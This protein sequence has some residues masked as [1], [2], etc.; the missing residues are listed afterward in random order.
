MISADVSTCVL[1]LQEEEEIRPASPK[2]DERSFFYTTPKLN[3]ARPALQRHQGTPW[4]GAAPCQ[5]SRDGATHGPDS[6]SSCASQP[7][8][9]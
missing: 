9:G 7:S 2:Y 6:C 5:R 4:A 3:P 1:C 8:V